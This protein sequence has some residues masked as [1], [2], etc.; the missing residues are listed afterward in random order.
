MDMIRPY[1][2]SWMNWGLMMRWASALTNWENY[3]RIEDQTRSQLIQNWVAAI[4]KLIKQ[5][6]QLEVLS[7][8]ETQ[9]GAVGERNTIISLKLL[10]DGKVLPL[11]V[12]KN[13]YYWLY[14]DMSCRFPADIR[15]SQ[16]EK[17]V[18][19][20]SF[21]IGQPVEVGNFAVLRIALGMHL[22][23][24]MEKFGVEK[25]LADDRVLLL[26]LSLL[27]K[28]HKTIAG[29]LHSSAAIKPQN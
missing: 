1:L 14:E 28:H 13:I 29:Q 2:P 18:L 27:Q 7:G 3:R 4:L 6:P 22:V 15:L 19:R 23:F 17:A 26:K 11:K 20:R 16:E 9:P 5:Y 21:L 25:A 10:S 12:V 8:G 24:F